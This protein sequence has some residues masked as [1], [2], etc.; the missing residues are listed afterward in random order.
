VCSIL[1]RTMFVLYV[2]CQTYVMNVMSMS[3]LCYEC[4]VHVKIVLMLLSLYI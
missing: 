2:L 3:N 1:S 4:Y